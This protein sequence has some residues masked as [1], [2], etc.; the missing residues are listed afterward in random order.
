MKKSVFSLL[1][2]S[3][4]LLASCK[5]ATFFQVYNIQSD[6]VQLANGV[7]QSENE[8]CRITYN[9]WS[10]GGNL[11][12]MI[13]NKSDKDMY[14]VMPQSFFILNGVANDYYSQSHYSRSVTNAIGGTISNGINVSGYLTNGN[15]WYPSRISRQFTA[16]SGVSSTITLGTTEMEL[17]CVPPKS[18]KFING[19]NISDHVY[20]DCE[21]KQQNYPKTTSNVV[22]Y[23]KEDTPVS[24]RNRIAYTFDK[25]LTDVRYVDH[26]FWLTS[27]QNYSQK[28]ATSIQKV[29]ECETNIELRTMQFDISSPD[30]FYNRYSM[31][32]NSSLSSGMHSVKKGYTGF[33]VGG[34]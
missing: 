28:A 2:L 23:T 3:M 22:R 1:T 31:I 4:I 14:I 18:A 16:I 6:N 17:V 19:F 21:N 29:R 30:R 12:F 27:L 24:F 32:R 9:L 7:L 5:P 33:L 13:H 25:N 26:S 20:K 8:D 15:L 10:E 34:H 11:S